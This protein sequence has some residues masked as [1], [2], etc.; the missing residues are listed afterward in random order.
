MLGPLDSTTNEHR[1][2]AKIFRDA[3][4][5]FEFLQSMR[6]TDQTLIGILK[7][8]RT[9]GGNAL[10]EQQWQALMNTQARAAQP[11]IPSAWYHS[12]YCWSVIRMASYMMSRKS[13]RK[14][15]QTLF[16]AQAVDQVKPTIPDTHQ[17]GFYESWLR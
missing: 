8:M 10:S 16:C 14:A 3:D 2:G 15:Q 9:S 12:C 6:F 17:A 5:V 7:V 4:L 11:E 1:F 13:A